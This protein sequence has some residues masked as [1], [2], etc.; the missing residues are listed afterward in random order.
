MSARARAMASRAREAEADPGAGSGRRGGFWRAVLI[1]SGIAAGAG[2]LFHLLSPVRPDLEPARD[3]EGGP[4]PQADPARRAA[5]AAEVAV[6]A[7]DAAA[8]VSA[9]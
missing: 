9:P 1:A 4:A 6:A 2:L 5:A 3:G 8:V 7:E